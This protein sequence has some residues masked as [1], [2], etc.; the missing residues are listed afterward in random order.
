MKKVEAA[1]RNSYL[2]ASLHL[3]IVPAGSSGGGGGGGSSGT[4]ELIGLARATSDHAF[5]ATIW[6]V[7]V[8]PAYQV[9]RMG[10]CGKGGQ[11]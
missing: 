1:L 9:R 5:N 3:R 11:V 6:D 10:G 7:I 2:V 4:E 8:D